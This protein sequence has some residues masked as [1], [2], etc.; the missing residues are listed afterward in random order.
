MSLEDYTTYTELDPNSR[1]TVAANKITAASLQTNTTAYIY[2]D[3]GVDFFDG[4]YTHY[5]DFEKTGGSG[6]SQDVFTWGLANVVANG[7]TLF[8]THIAH[9]VFMYA[10]TNPILRLMDNRGGSTAFDDSIALALNTRYWLTL[11]R[12]ESV[13]SFGPKS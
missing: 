11:D 12:D 13:G 3:K 9:Q 7:R 1:L 4:D 5:L 2:D 6:A 10:T 8:T